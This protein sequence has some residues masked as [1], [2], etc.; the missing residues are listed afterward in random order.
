MLPL[1]SKEAIDKAKRVLEQMEQEIKSYLYDK[2]FILSLK[3]VGHF[4]VS[5]GSE[6]SSVLYACIDKDNHEDSKTAT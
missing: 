1:D 2:N 6:E 4:P 3:G 5:K